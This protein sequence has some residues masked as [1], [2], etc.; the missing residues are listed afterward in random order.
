MG[1]TMHHFV[2]RCKARAMPGT[3]LKI[4]LPACEIHLKFKPRIAMSQKVREL[5]KKLKASQ[6]KARQLKIKI[7]K[8]ED[9]KA[10]RS[11]TAFVEQKSKSEFAEYARLK[12]V[13]HLPAH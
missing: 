8:L 9:E 12:T 1:A 10:S 13:K 11:L 3:V 6:D 7:E 4:C 5:N 2:L